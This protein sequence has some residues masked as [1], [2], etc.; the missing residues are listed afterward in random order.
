MLPSGPMKKTSKDQEWTERVLEAE[1]RL[2]DA[3]VTHFKHAMQWARELPREARLDAT[4][5]ATIL[6]KPV[7]GRLRLVYERPGRPDDLVAELTSVDREL[8]DFYSQFD[9]LIEQALRSNANP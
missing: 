7:D 2:H 9:D 3:G 4:V 1:Q 5:D 6:L 8:V